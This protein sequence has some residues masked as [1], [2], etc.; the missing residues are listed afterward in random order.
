MPHRLL[1]II[2][3][4]M[5]CI[6]LHTKHCINVT[7]INEG[8][9]NYILIEFQI[10]QSI[11]VQ[12]RTIFNRFLPSTPRQLMLSKHSI[13]KTSRITSFFMCLR[14][15]N[16]GIRNLFERH[17]SSQVIPTLESFIQFSEESCKT[18][19]LMTTVQVISTPRKIK[20]SLFTQEE[21]FTSAN[22]K[23]CSQK[24]GIL[25]SLCKKSH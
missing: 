14:N 10:Y 6:S 15:L 19:E 23:N 20:Q 5:T 8:W 13:F 4:Q 16:N 12:I 24:V 9:V 25:C 22:I 21:N 18:N 3:L 2:S 11:R 17:C 7:I 1:R